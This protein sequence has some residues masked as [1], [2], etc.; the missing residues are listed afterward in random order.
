MNVHFQLVSPTL[1]LRH[2]AYTKLLLIHTVLYYTSTTVQNTTRSFQLIS[3]LYALLQSF[4]LDSSI[5]VAFFSTLSSRLVPPIAQPSFVARFLIRFSR[6]LFLASPP[7]LPIS[8]YSSEPNL[9]FLVCPCFLLPIN[10]NQNPL[11]T[12]KG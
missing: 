6:H 7:L 1:N 4:C 3:F 12:F 5:S 8:S 11:K 2:F 10:R 9:F